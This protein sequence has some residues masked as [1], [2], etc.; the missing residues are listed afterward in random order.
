MRT[1]DWQCFCTDITR[2]SSPKCIVSPFAVQR[3][4]GA[5]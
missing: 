3:Q 1:S 2:C 4:Q 5:V